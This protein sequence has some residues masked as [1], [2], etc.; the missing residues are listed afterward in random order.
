[1]PAT[2]PKG[3]TQE[4][5]SEVYLLCKQLQPM[6]INYSEDEVINEVPIKNLIDGKEYMVPVNKI[7]AKRPH[8][9]VDNHFSGENVMN[10]LGRTALE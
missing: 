5:P 7:Y 2:R 8:I 1:M 3:C 10:L 9:T 6:V 4:G